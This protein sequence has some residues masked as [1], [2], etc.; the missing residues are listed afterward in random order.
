[1]LEFT[2]ECNLSLLWTNT[3]L[4]EALVLVSGIW[5]GQAVSSAFHVSQ[6]CVL[7]GEM[8]SRIFLQTQI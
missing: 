1:M 5:N 3:D 8:N 6:D 7:L 4:E 2:S